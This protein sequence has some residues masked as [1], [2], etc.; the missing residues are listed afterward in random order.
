VELTSLRVFRAWITAV[1][2]DSLRHCRFAPNAADHFYLPERYTDPFGHVT[3]LEF[4]RHDLFPQSSC[5]P[6]GNTTTVKQFDYRVLA[7][8]EM[9][10]INDN[11]SEVVFDVLGL[12]T[13]MA[14]KGKGSEGDELD[15]LTDALID[16]DLDTRIQFFAT[17]FHKT[18]ARRLLA[19]ATARHIYSFG[20]TRATEGSIH[21]G[22]HPPCAAAILREQHVA[23]LAP[24]RE[25]PLQVAFEYSD[26]GGNVL[27]KKVQAEPETR[28]GPLRWVASGKTILNNKGKPV[29][30]YE[31]YFSTGELG[32]PDQPALQSRSQPASRS[33]STTMPWGGSF[34]R[35]CPTALS[36]ASS[37]RPGM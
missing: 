34:V 14:V 30:Q 24:G 22:D 5:D 7:P 17:A 1:I 3:T 13:A 35:K 21:Y 2:L 26:G 27:V 31:P 36:V 10:D 32:R 37:F 6:V 33:S 12:P 28:G 25:S 18:E 29:K 16:P 11:L 8:R 20:E 4:D 9:E 19:S 15:D 23:P